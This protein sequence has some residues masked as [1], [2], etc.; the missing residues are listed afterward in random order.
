MIWKRENLDLFCCLFNYV[1]IV[2]YILGIGIRLC[3]ENFDQL[4]FGINVKREVQIK[5]CMNLDVKFFIVCFL[6]D[7]K[8]Q[9]IF[10][11]G[12]EYK[13]RLDLQR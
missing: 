3:I 10:Q 12:F 4:L 9:K 11:L 1:L 7:L 13:I 5:Y 8:E 6:K 2:C